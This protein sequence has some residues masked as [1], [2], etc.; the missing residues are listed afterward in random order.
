MRLTI[1][2]F[3]VALLGARSQQGPTITI[4]TADDSRSAKSIAIKEIAGKL[5]VEYE[6]LDGKSESLLCS[7]V[8]EIAMGTPTA[9]A[10]APATVEV[11]TTVGDSIFGTLGEPGADAVE[12]T[13]PGLGKASFPFTTID[14]VRFLTNRSTWPTRHLPPKGRNSDSVWTIT[15]DERKGTLQ[16]F[17]GTKGVD[18]ERKDKKV[19]TVSLAN[20]AAAWFA[21]TNDTKIPEAPK[22]LYSVILLTDGSSI[23]GTISS[24]AGGSFTFSDLYGTPRTVPAASV[25]GIYYKNGRVVYLSDVAPSSRDEN[26]NYIRTEK[27]QPGDLSFPAKFDRSVLGEPLKI[28]G[29]AFRKGVGVHAFSSLTWKLDKQFV[30]FQAT[31]GIDDGATKYAPEIGNVAFKVLVDGAEVLD[32]GTVTSKDKPRPIVVDVTNKTTITLIVTF[33]ADELSQGDLAD[34]ALARVIR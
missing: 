21:A 17:S 12:V 18:L 10:V 27:P 13:S 6:R 8:V 15:G 32:S 29:Q 23:A 4:T 22:S 5:C 14:Q 11:I 34:W 9:P 28:R 30:K 19:I 25:A 26:P 3:L 24:F 31:I 2:A 7:D 20:A 1:A 16:Q 33:G